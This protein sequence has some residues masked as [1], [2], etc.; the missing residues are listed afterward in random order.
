KAW[1]VLDVEPRKYR[2]RVVNAS[3]TRFYNLSLHRADGRP[4]PNFRQVGTELGLLDMPL[5]LRELLLAPAE[6][7]DIVVD[8]SSV[9]GQTLI[10]R[11]S[12][13]TPFPLGSDPDPATTGQ[14]MAFRVKKGWVRDN[15]RLPARLRPWFLSRSTMSQDC[16]TPISVVRQLTT[17]D[18]PD[19]FG[20]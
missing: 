1:P 9:A 8:F 2:F 19:A 10:L 3:D 12:A 7:A 11:N 20:R 14:V 15:S 13:Q 5:S 18:A 17:S 4:G 6:R 16:G